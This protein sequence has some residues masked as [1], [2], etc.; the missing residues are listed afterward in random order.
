MATEPDLIH[1]AALKL[2]R[3]ARE[4]GH[5]AVEVRA[6]AYVSLNGRPAVRLV[7]PSVD[8]AAQRRDVWHDDWIEPAPSTPAP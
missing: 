8:L 5:R 1:Q 4:V 3:V 7:D 6:D 2:A